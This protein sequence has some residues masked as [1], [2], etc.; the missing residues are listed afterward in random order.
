MREVNSRALR[1]AARSFLVGV[2]AFVG[3]CLP[4]STAIAQGSLKSARTFRTHP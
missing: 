1:Y 4:A 2:L 3:V